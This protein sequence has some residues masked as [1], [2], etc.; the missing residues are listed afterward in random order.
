MSQMDNI[1]V[2][3]CVLVWDVASDSYR[4]V[5][6]KPSVQALV[7]PLGEVS[8]R[9][10]D[11]SSRRQVDQ[12]S[13]LN[14][15]KRSTLSTAQ[16]V[17]SS[18]PRQLFKTLPP[19]HEM[20]RRSQVYVS[21]RSRISLSDGYRACDKIL[22]HYYVQGLLRFRIL[23]ASKIVS[24]NGSHICYSLS[25]EEIINRPAL[26]RPYLKTLLRRRSLTTLL[27]RAP[28]LGQFI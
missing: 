28:V 19:R 2:P 5:D 1:P 20:V 13:R 10:V 15:S 18:M 14:R 22:S 7:P 16:I 26:L 25:Q 3:R 8:S 27:E 11:Q 17:P 9:Q 23:P 4:M 6:R 12:P 21:H 24:S